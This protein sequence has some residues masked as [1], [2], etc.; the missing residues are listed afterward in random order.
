MTE[1]KSV[2]LPLGYTP[3]ARVPAKNN[4]VSPQGFEPRT[5]G[6]EGRCSI[7]LSYEP[8][9]IVER[10]MRIELTPSAWKAE[11]LP[12]NYIRIKLERKTRFELATLA[13]ARRCSTPEPLPHIYGDSTGNRTPVTAV[14]GRC[15]DRLTMEPHNLRTGNVLLSRAVSHQVSSALRSLTS[16][17][18]MG[19]GVSSPL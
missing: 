17:F 19:T 9:K 11:V 12:L 3:S 8:T 4:M 13:L 16:V 5:H 18:E 1:S 6:L 10:M 15:L 14:K 7:Q 2:A